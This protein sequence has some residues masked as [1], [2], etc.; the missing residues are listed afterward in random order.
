M[1]EEKESI[2][3]SVYIYKI[4]NIMYLIQTNIEYIKKFW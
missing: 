4:Y 2:C 3:V 1:K